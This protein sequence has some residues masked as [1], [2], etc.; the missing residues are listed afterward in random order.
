MFSYCLWFF[1]IG[2]PVKTGIAVVFVKPTVPTTVVSGKGVPFWAIKNS[3]GE[4]YGEQ[5]R[6][7]CSQKRENTSFKGR[8]RS[9]NMTSITDS[10]IIELQ[11]L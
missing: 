4:D 3:W 1:L 6:P 9:G 5:V 10:L 2:V 7:H 8:K 11:I